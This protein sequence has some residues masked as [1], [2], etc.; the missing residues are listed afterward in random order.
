M[1]VVL[2]AITSI[3]LGFV[4]SAQAADLKVE[5]VDCS[6]YI[7][8]GKKMLIYSFKRGETCETMYSKLNFVSNPQLSVTN[9]KIQLGFT[10]R[11]VRAGTLVCFP[12]TK[13]AGACPS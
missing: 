8:R 3:S 7:C 13:A 5:T 9:A 11:G 1:R 10:C 4:A 2:F 6:K 12:Q